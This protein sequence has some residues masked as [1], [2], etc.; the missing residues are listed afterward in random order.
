MSTRPAR[1]SANPIPPL[2]SLSLH[3]LISNRLSKFKAPRKV[4]AN[5]ATRF[6]VYLVLFCIFALIFSPSENKK[7]RYQQ[8][9][10]QRYD[11]PLKLLE[12]IEQSNPK[13]QQQQHD[14]DESKLIRKDYL[15][16]ISNFM[17]SAHTLAY[18]ESRLINHY[19]NDENNVQK[20]CMLV[21]I[22]NGKATFQDDFKGLRHGRS[23]SV[24]YIINRI[25]SH[26]ILN[27]QPHLP[28]VVFP[29]MVTDGHGGK[30]ATFGSAR[31]W[32][33]WVN[34]LPVPMGNSRGMEQGWGTLL[35][36]WDHYIKTRITNSHQNYTWDSK[37][38]K[39][40]FRGSLSMQTYKLGSCNWQNNHR[41]QR[42]KNWKDCTRGVLYLRSKKNPELFDVAFTSNKPKPMSPKNVFD[43]APPIVQSLPF[44]DGQ[45]YKYQINVGNNQDWAERLRVLLFT[46]SAIVMHE[47][48]TKEF[49]S[50]LL[51][52]WIHY[53]PTN[54]MMTDLVENVKWATEHDDQVKQIVRQHLAFAHRYLSENA[55]YI[56]WELAI[57]EFA[58]RQQKSKITSSS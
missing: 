5:Q 25:I 2:L 57:E 19:E 15:K 26:R 43:G 53:I 10:R 55:M 8:L 29:V 7:A 45:K 48:E 27:K 41:C 11:I 9:R 39:A 49:F 33:H 38:E 22:K 36:G 52:P 56:Y 46:N 14:E 54:V 6:I 40:T 47:A 17:K 35:R 24:K 30:V 28:D 20:T 44:L 50:P 3:P 34:I 58:K 13:K 12:P 23:G 31:H 21:T 32:S 18:N 37:I 51:Q 4:F 1:G 16:V 42:A